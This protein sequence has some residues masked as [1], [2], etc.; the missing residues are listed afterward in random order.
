MSVDI[1]G[2][3]ALLGAVTEILPLALVEQH[4]ENVHEALAVISHALQSTADADATTAI[5]LMAQSLDRIRDVL[6]RLTAA[7]D[8]LN[9]YA[10]TI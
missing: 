10:S 8:H 3:R 7:I 2:V 1:S 9:A 4:R 5:L 6:D